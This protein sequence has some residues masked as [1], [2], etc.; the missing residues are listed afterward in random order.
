MATNKIR[1]YANY[2]SGV[3][4]LGELGGPQGGAG[5]ALEEM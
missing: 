2:G 3:S 1:E 5:C 4:M